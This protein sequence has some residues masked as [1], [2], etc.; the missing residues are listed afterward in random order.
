P[1][2]GGIEA[3]KMILEHFPDTTVPII[4]MTA[5][6]LPQDKTDCLNAG[7]TDFISKP[8]NKDAFIQ[9]VKKYI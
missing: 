4:A 9:V 1:I 6:V 5:N 3:T 7:M 2:M 8:V